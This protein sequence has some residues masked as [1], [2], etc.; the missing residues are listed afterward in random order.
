[1]M[2]TAPT[3]PTPVDSPAEAL[4]TVHRPEEANNVDAL[5]QSTARFTR[6]AWDCFLAL[7]ADWQAL[8]YERFRFAMQTTDA[9]VASTIAQLLSDVHVTAIKQEGSVLRFNTTFA[10]V[11]AVVKHAGVQLIDA[12]PAKAV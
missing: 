9:N 4:P 5:T 12:T 8:C 2:T 6:P 3:S 1:M 11:Q 10:K 7:R